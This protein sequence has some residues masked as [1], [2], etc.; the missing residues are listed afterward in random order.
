[1]S[2]ER[3]QP[4]MCCRPSSEREWG[5]V[6]ELSELL[7]LRGADFVIAGYDRYPF[8]RLF[9]TSSGL[10]YPGDSSDQASGEVPV[11]E[12]ISRMYAEAEARKAPQKECNP[13]L[14]KQL[15]DLAKQVAAA[16]GEGGSQLVGGCV[17]LGLGKS[18][19][20]DAGPRVVSDVEALL[21]RLEALEAA[22]DRHLQ[23]HRAVTSASVSVSQGGAYTVSYK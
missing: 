5:A 7:G 14:R 23:E 15:E 3:L 22:F 2:S 10:V 8:I 11:P 13:V 1:M 18:L 12:F 16:Y 6:L 4:G 19:V 9:G 17:P 21:R 20:E